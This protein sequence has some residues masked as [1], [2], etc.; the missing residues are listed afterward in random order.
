MYIIPENPYF[1]AGFWMIILHS[2]QLFVAKI[3]KKGE[4]VQ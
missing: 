3:R 4:N 1:A 2:L